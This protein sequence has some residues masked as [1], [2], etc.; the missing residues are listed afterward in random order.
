MTSL[1]KVFQVESVIPHLID[2]RTIECFLSDFK[3]D[4]EDYRPCYQND[5]NPPSHSRNVELEKDRSC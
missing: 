4:R 3:F 1:V 2:C 5:I